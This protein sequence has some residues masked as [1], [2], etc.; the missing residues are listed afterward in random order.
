MG[1]MQQPMGVT[2]SKRHVLHIY[3]RILFICVVY[4]AQRMGVKTPVLTDKRGADKAKH[5]KQSVTV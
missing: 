3:A 5:E 2:F 1:A 4:N